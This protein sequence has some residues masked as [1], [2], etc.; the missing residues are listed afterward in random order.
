MDVRLFT[1]ATIA[2]DETLVVAV[3]PLFVDVGSEVDDVIVAVLLICDAGVDAAIVP[4]MVIV[5]VAESA[6]E[7][8]VHWIVVVPLHDQPGAE[9]DVNWNA[10]GSGSVITTLVASL[11]PAFVT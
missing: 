8:I 6:S 11:G 5:D 2:G 9:T 1:A 4:L 10:A 3:A 7:S